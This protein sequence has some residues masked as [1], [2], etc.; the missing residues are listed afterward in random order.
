[1][2]TNLTYDTLKALRKSPRVNKSYECLED[3][4]LVASLRQP[5]ICKS[6]FHQVFCDNN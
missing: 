1:M 3:V 4:R 2:N 5:H 6:C